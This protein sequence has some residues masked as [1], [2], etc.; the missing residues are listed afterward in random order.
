M[1]QNK[2]QQKKARKYRQL[3]QYLPVFQ[4]IIQ[5]PL[6]N[7]LMTQNESHWN[8][9][10]Y[11]FTS[12]TPEGERKNGG[13]W[14]GVGGWTLCLDM[15]VAHLSLPCFSCSEWGPQRREA[16]I[17]ALQ[18]CPKRNNKT[19]YT[20][21]RMESWQ[22]AT[23]L[24]HAMKLGGWGGGGRKTFIIIYV[25]KCSASIQIPHIQTVLTKLIEVAALGHKE[26]L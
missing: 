16:G 15:L 8:K 1:E 17:H 7:S 11:L 24:H 26:D 14:W 25:S 9:F 13:G 6:R 21:T 4:F 12:K 10:I 18:T 5:L 20:L 22:Q 3:T 19:V 23:K 2:Q